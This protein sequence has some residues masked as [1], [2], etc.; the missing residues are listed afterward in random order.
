MIRSALR[1]QLQNPFYR[2]RGKPRPR[3]RIPLSR[4]KG[5]AEPPRSSV[6]KYFC[7]GFLSLALCVSLN[8]FIRRKLADWR[9]DCG[10]W[11]VVNAE[12]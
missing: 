3:S 8:R 4:L 12:L 5:T 10:F 7:S 11:D 6:F 2:I 1:R 9:Y